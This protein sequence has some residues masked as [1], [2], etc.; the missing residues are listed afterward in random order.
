MMLLPNKL[1]LQ[2]KLMLPLMLEEEPI[3]VVVEVEKNIKNE[4][5]T[6]RKK[7]KIEEIKKEQTREIN[8][9]FD[10]Y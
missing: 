9:L 6:G 5:Q 3:M 1:L 8:Y 7:I 2:N 4:M 10:K